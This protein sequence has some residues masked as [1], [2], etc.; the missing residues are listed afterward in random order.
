MGITLVG[1]KDEFN[2][3]GRSGIDHY[4]FEANQITYKIAKQLL[5]KSPYKNKINYI[6]QWCV[7][8]TK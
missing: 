4:A 5:N 2:S 8:Q 6:M 1:F 3:T 7:I